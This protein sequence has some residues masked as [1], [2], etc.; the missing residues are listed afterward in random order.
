VSVTPAIGAK[1]V[2]GAMFTGPMEKWVGNKLIT[3]G[4]YPV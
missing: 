1:T 4:F 2:A 3:R